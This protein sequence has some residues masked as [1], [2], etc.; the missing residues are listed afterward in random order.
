MLG[1]NCGR[2]GFIA[3]LEH[4]DIDKLAQL[5]AEKGTRFQEE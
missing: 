1:I 3:S 2:L 4:N 5:A